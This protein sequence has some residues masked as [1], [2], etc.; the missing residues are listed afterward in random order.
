MTQYFT[1]SLRLMM[2]HFGPNLDLCE[3]LG[4]AHD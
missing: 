3:Q 1:L 4:K 2:S